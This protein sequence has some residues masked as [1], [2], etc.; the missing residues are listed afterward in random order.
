MKTKHGIRVLKNRRLLL[1]TF[2]STQ[3][4]WELFWSLDV[5]EKD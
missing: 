5:P 3:E 4:L 1:G 2:L